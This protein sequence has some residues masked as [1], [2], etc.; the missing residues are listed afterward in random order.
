M[1]LNAVPPSTITQPGIGAEIGGVV[2]ARGVG[3]QGSGAV[4]VPGRQPVG[5]DVATQRAQAPAVE[6]RAIERRGDERRK[7]KLP[8]LL[9]MRVGPRRTSR[10][11]AGDGPASSVDTKV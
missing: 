7:Q 9:D 3:G 8:V 1:R 11:R 5:P 10:R 6:R 4:L 2:A